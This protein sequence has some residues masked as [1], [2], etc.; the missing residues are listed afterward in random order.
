VLRLRHALREY[1]PAALEAFDLDAADTLELLGKAPE[2]VSAAKLTR[3]Q[4]RAALTRARRRDIDTKATRIQEALRSET[5]RTHPHPTPRLRP[6]QHLHPSPSPHSHVDKHHTT[7][8]RQ[9]TKSNQENPYPNS[10]NFG[11]GVLRSGSGEKISWEE[12]WGRAAFGRGFNRRTG[13]RFSRFM[14]I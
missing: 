3:G 13:L 14:R 1:F 9:N 8:N 6:H 11:L 10:P 2:P 5:H 12:S 7:R 4:I